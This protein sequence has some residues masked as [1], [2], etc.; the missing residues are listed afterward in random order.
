MNTYLVRNANKKFKVTRWCCTANCEQC[1]SYRNGKHKRVI[2]MLTDDIDVARRTFK[3]WHEYGPILF[4]Q[5][6][7]GFKELNRN[8]NTY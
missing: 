6:K 7:Y 5:T 3:N 2:Q 8:I 4:E 1:C